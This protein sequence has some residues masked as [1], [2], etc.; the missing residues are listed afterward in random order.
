MYGCKIRKLLHLYQNNDSYRTIKSPSIGIYKV[1]GSKFFGYAYPISSE[2]E[3]K[4]KIEE[5]KKTHHTARHHCYAYR[6]KPDYSIYRTN[7][8]GEPKNAAGLPILGQIDGKNLTNVALI[9]VRYFG[10]TKL[11][12]GG[13]MS[14][15]KE[16]ALKTLNNAD[17]IDCTINL[18]FKVNFGYPE[19]NSVMRFTKELGGIITNKKLDV[20]CVIYFTIR[21]NDAKKVNDKFTGLKNITITKL[22]Q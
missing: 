13:M 4:I 6:F 18:M 14:A 10:G 11:G 8:D 15:Y 21:Q 17:I 16:T 20:D 5:I 1:R 19:M 22:D 9:V 7:D 2:K 3:F 12:I